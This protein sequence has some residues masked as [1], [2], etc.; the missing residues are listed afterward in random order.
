MKSVCL[1]SLRL[2]RWSC[3]LWPSLKILPKNLQE[4]INQIENLTNT[5]NVIDKNDVQVVMRQEPLV[6]TNQIPMPNEIHSSKPEP[7]KKKA[8]K[9]SQNEKVKNHPF[10]SKSK[11]EILA[12]YINVETSVSQKEKLTYSSQ[13]EKNTIQ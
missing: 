10:Q 4:E 5:Q 1:P 8:T 9:K 7:N 6:D 2:R 12:E 13:L 11:Q 3:F